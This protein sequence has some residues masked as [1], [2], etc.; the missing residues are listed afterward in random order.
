M[1]S[2]YYDREGRPITMERYLFLSRNLK[3]KQVA[4]DFTPTGYLV[5]TVWLGNDHNYD[6][7]GAPLIFE[8][9]VFY[10]SGQ[11]GDGSDLDCLRWSTEEEARAGHARMM[12]KWGDPVRDASVRLGGY[13]GYDGD[14]FEENP[15]KPGQGE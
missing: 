8:T 5:S 10:P 9:M 12:A 3:Y 14:D 4:R 1:R 2:A 15:P 13:S 7:D 11:G 6:E